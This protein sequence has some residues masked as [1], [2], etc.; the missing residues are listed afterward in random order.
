MKIS[1]ALISILI[2]SAALPV[3][4]SSQAGF[5][6]S[7]RDLKGT[8]SQLTDTTKEVTGFSKEVLGNRAG[9]QPQYT[10]GYNLGQNLSPKV[11]NLPLY[12]GANKSGPVMTRLSKSSTLV[13][14]GNSHNSG[15]IEVTTDYGNGWVEAH[16]VH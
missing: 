1:N 2:L 8:L 13:F 4:I 5:A 7:L 14:A 16:L 11:N 12:Q 10:T 6:D 3:S 15:L 9:T